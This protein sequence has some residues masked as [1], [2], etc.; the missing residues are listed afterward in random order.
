LAGIVLER[1]RSDEYGPFFER[2]VARVP[3]NDALSFLATQHQSLLEELERVPESRGGHRYAEGKWSI[4]EV[5]GHMTDA[6]RI[7]AYRA[8][9]IARGEQKSLPGFDE[10]A[11]MN[12]TPFASYTLRDLLAEFGQVRTANLSLLSHLDDAAWRRAGNA[13]G[14]NVSVRALAFVMAG[15]VE[16]HRSVLRER[17]GIA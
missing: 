3:G 14:Y 16:H 11:Y 7:M 9:C 4:R 5:I 8:L 12:E 13:N 15:H 6:E 2:Y 10:N 1:P 17:Y